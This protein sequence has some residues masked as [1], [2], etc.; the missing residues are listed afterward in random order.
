MQAVTV[1]T[2]AGPISI[3]TEHGNEA[4]PVRVKL[5]QGFMS[6]TVFLSV[7]QVH[8]LGNALAQAYTEVAE[9]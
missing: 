2:S 6:M 4:A 1:Q 5:G 8:Q 3:D 9:A 7:E